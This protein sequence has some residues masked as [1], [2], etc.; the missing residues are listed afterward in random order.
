LYCL[1]PLCTVTEVI[2]LAFSCHRFVLSHVHPCYLQV[3]TQA[4]LTSRVLSV[5]HIL[6]SST[7]STVGAESYCCTW[8][9]THTHTYTP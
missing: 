7:Y 9:H 6:T 1:I 4:T 8:S 2:C 5:F 3:I